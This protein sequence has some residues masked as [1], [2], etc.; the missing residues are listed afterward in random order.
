MFPEAV[1]TGT[2]NPCL[3][4]YCQNVIRNYLKKLEVT[5]FLAFSVGRVIVHVSL[6]SMP[7]LYDV[8]VQKPLAVWMASSQVFVFL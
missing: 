4:I 2:W 3:L 7:K 8:A 6:V 1:V 5:V